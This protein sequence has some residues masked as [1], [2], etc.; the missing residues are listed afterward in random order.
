MRPWPL[1][2]PYLLLFLLSMQIE[3][4]AKTDCLSLVYLWAYFSWGFK[5]VQLPVPVSCPEGLCAAPAPAVEFEFLRT[6]KIQAISA[7]PSLHP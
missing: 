3:S 4:S 2:S 7:Y 5:P 6:S 1:T